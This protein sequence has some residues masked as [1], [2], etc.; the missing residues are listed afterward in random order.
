MSNETMRSNPLE[1]LEAIVER[2]LQDALLQ[3]EGVHCSWQPDQPLTEDS[4][5]IAETPHARIAY[6]WNPIEAED[7]FSQPDAVS[8]WEGWENDDSEPASRFFDQLDSLWATAG[9]QNSLTERFG[10]RLPQPLLSAIARRAQAIA[11]TSAT[12]ADQLVQSVQDLLP[13]LTELV[14][15]DVYVLAR[16]LAHA[17]RGEAT[18]DPVSAVRSSEWEQLS[19]TEQVRL[20][21]AVAHYALAELKQSEG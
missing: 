3:A 2:E 11:A 13:N 9:L 21:L 14:E 18:I 1:N 8:V 19:E 16:P 4:V 15:E 12:L 10:L 17:M 6:P 7:F 5:T 20:S